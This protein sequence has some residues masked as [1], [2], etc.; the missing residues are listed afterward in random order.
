[1]NSLRPFYCQ[2]QHCNTVK[3]VLTF[4]FDV[5]TTTVRTF[6][7]SFRKTL[8]PRKRISLLTQ[9]FRDLFTSHVPR[10]KLAAITTT[11][12]PLLDGR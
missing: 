8:R 2:L 1:M 10:I 12:F 9:G 7:L 4:F 3:H 6:K 5:K 11:Y